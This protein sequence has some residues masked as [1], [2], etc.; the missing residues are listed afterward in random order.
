MTQRRPAEASPRGDC[1]LI[2]W[3]WNTPPPTRMKHH[4]HVS[5]ASSV[6]SLLLPSVGGCSPVVLCHHDRFLSTPTAGRS[7]I[8]CRCYYCPELL[9]S[10]FLHCQITA[11]FYLRGSD[12]S[13][14]YIPQ[15]LTHYDNWGYG[16]ILLP[17]LFLLTTLGFFDTILFP[18]FSSS[19]SLIIQSIES[20]RIHTSY[21]RNLKN[22]KPNLKPWIPYYYNCVN[23]AVNGTVSH[24]MQESSWG[25][26]QITLSSWVWHSR[27]PHIFSQVFLIVSIWKGSF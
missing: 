25:K 24:D 26:R 17:S 11:T 1:N 13:S 6:K 7:V 21:L 10:L 22:F 15:T 8:N 9:W 14:V 12:S 3:L 18:V 27:K 2:T 19:L 23:R 4:W 20:P 16:Q 5:L